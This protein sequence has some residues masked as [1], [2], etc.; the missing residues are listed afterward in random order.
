MVERAANYLLFLDGLNR[1]VGLYW[2]HQFLDCH[3]EYFKCKQKPLAVEWKNAHNFKD[4]EEYFETFR[5]LVEWFGLAPENMWNMDETG[6]KISCGKAQWV[7]TSDA[8]K[9]LVMTDPN[10][11]EYITST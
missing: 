2:T 8:S 11:Q 1:E 3:L 4:M 5:K 9:A 7:I 6:F 10:N